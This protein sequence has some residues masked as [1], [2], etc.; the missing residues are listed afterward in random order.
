[1]VKYSVLFVIA[2]NHP[3]GGGYI[4][5]VVS[6][7]LFVCLS[8]KV[9]IKLSPVSSLTHATYATQVFTQG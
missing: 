2:F 1:M 9:G 5:S 6:V 4:I 8:R 3:R 7:C